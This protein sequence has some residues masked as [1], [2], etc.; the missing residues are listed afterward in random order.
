M[1]SATSRRFRSS[2]SLGQCKLLHHVLVIIAQLI[3]LL[4]GGALPGFDASTIVEPLDYDFTKFGG[5]KSVI[6]EP[7]QEK[8]IAMYA[9]M[10]TLVKQIAGSFVQ[11]PENP[12]ATDL[13]E[14]L[15]QLTMSESYGPM[16]DG[17]TA[18]YAELCSQSPSEEELKKLPPRIR[19]LFFQWMA[20]Q[21]RPELDAAD[22]KTPLRP[23]RI[24]QGG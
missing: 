21:M 16:L 8:V 20:K 17:M 15:N 9:A 5:S 6:P 4:L 1:L 7:S 24:A 2:T 13:V 11:L 22:S 18:I 3:T 14:S 12:S 19:A 23:L 10:D